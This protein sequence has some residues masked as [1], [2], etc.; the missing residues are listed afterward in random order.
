MPDQSIIDD[1]KAMIAVSRKRPVNFGLCLGKKPEG[2]LIQFDRK[3]A[4][5]F[6]AKRVKKEGETNK[7]AFGTAETDGKVLSL[8]LEDKSPSGLVR[9]GK[10]Y[11]KSIG[12]GMKLVLLSPDGTVLEA[13]EDISDEDRDTGEKTG[14]QDDAGQ[15]GANPEAEKWRAVCEKLD[16]SVQAALTGGHPSAGKIGA[17]WEMAANK[18]Q[19]DDYATALKIAAKIAPLLS[20]MPVDDN[21]ADPN[22]ERWAKVA[23]VLEP[24]ILAALKANH[25]EA[26]KIR[27]VWSFAQEKAEAGNAAASLKAAQQLQSLLTAAP[28]ASPQDAPPQNVVAF[29]RS[30]IMWLD[31][32]K[33]MRADM[34][35]FSAAVAQ[36]SA[37]DDDQSDV[38][39][40]V[41]QIMGEFEAFDT[42]LEDVLDTITQTPEGGERTTLKKQ[43]AQTIGEYLMVLDRPFFKAIDDNPFEPVNVAARGRQSLS[44]VQSTLA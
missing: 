32:K 5:S 42:R 12:L 21:P 40:V 30:R 25:P 41:N 3:K 6:L 2:L 26:G 17:A 44:V 15:D 38:E 1:I 9:H 34:Q 18:A 31:A 13:D 36:Q 23:A 27:A 4:P 33:A 39:A 10:G 16:P 22:A 43:A 28:D 35:K 11:F 19:A 8:T 14:N 7:I 24:K 37:D 29:Q 20:Q